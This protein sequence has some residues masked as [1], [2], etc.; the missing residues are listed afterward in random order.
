VLGSTLFTLGLVEVLFRFVMP[1]STHHLMYRQSPDPAIGV[2]LLPD[3]EF[4]FAGVPVPIP[5]SRVAISSQGL[6]E[7]MVTRP[8]PTGVRRLL[9][10]GDSTTFGWGVNIN[11]TFCRRLE[12][13]LGAGWTTINLGVPGYNPSQAVRRFEV[14]GLPLEPD[15]VVLLL[16]SNDYEAP[17]DW[18][19]RDSLLAAVVRA[20]ALAR[21]IRVQLLQSRVPPE[22][23]GVGEAIRAFQQLISLSKRHGFGVLVLTP[24]ATGFADLTPALDAESVA[25]R[26]IE[27]A[28][29]GQPELTI[30]GD[31]HPNADGHAAIAALIAEQ[32][33]TRGLLGLRV[34]ATTAP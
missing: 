12:T 7:R 20:S 13:L 10:V 27:S 28:F 24:D 26:S 34:D 2:E 4:D 6:R 21:W 16:Q 17:L 33:Q 1:P 32:L 3:S 30:P 14:H 15:L 9:C 29:S 8:K 11:Q 19:D 25:H 22:F 23:D 5:A 31:G 18:G